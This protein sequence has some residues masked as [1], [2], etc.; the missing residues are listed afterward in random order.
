[1]GMASN[2]TQ[3]TGAKERDRR[4]SAAAFTGCRR[5]EAGGYE[6]IVGD[7]HLGTFATAVEAAAA[8]EAAEIRGEGSPN[9]QA[10]IDEIRA[11]VT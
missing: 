7:R 4:H 9:L 3:S 10:Y 8:V 1:M 2:K 5:R 11:A 6:A